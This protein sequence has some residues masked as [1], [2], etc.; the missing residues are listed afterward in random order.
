MKSLFYNIFELEIKEVNF[1]A[2]STNKIV[3]GRFCQKSSLFYKQ[4]IVN[5]VD[6]LCGK[7]LSKKDDF[8]EKDS[9]TRSYPLYPQLKANFLPT[10]K[11]KYF[12]EK[13]T[14]RSVF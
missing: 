2:I 8:S 13:F 10:G 1:C 3:K 4:L 7:N 12:C 6:N 9:Y 5:N 11:K 14:N